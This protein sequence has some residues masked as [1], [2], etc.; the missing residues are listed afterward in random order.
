MPRTRFLFRD[1]GLAVWLVLAAVGCTDTVGPGDE[2]VRFSAPV[3]GQPMEDIF[4][5]AYMDH[6]AGGQTV[7]DYMC[8]I[9]SFPG[10]G[11][12]DILLQDF[13][14]Q[15]AGVPVLASAGG[16]VVGV[17]D[18]MHDRNTARGA[19]GFGNHVVIDHHDGRGTRSIYAHLRRNSVQVQVG[20]EVS[21]GE[22]LGLVGSSG[23]SNWPH[24]HFEVRRDQRRVDPFE[25]PC[26]SRGSLWSQQLSY[27]NEFK[28]TDQGVLDAPVGSGSD[29]LS[30][31]L[32]R[33]SDLQTVA[34]DTEWV[35]YWL[36]VVNQ[37]AADMRLEVRDPA[38]AL[39]EERH[40]SFS[41][42]YSLRYITIS[43]RAAEV[44]TGSGEWTMALYQNGL[45][46]ASR[47]VEVHEVPTGAVFS[48]RTVLWHRGDALPQ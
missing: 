15:D 42:G 17:L 25:G 18:G 20:D 23:S 47:T 19:G 48:G 3:P 16:T 27:Q 26:G 29:A 44:F 41:P 21:R 11:G 2:K 6:G 28:V 7:E 36:Q 22:E 39:R 8:G 38:G 5:G 4:Y 46:I 37:P 40:R 32:E 45:P 13:R 33:P 24:L 30:V 10:H 43:M 9:K 35:V 1:Y 12:V 14:R 34:S 31:L